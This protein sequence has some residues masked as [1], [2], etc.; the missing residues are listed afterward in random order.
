LFYFDFGKQEESHDFV[1]V[2]LQRKDLN[3]VPDIASFARILQIINLMELK[4]DDVLPYFIRST[5]RYMSTHKQLFEVEKIFLK[6][7]KTMA[8]ARDDAR[9]LK[10]LAACKKELE[11]FVT[12]PL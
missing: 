10:V 1:N 3:T 11:P 9:F 4:S 6:Y 8:A 7:L 12:I 5:L 2:L